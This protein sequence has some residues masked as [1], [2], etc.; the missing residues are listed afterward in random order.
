M[1]KRSLAIMTRQRMAILDVLRGTASHPTAD[2][3]YAQVRKI[4]PNISLGTV[5]RNLNLLRE[6]GEIQELSYGSGFRRFDGNPKEHPHFACVSCRRVFDLELDLDEEL[7]RKA[8]EVSGYKVLR[9]R[10]E[11]EGVCGDCLRK[12]KREDQQ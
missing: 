5:Y 2:W 1:I 7:A 10:V 3:I 12:E 11:F 9:T 6:A 8:E 4:L